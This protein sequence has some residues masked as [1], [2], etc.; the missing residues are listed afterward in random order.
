MQRKEEDHLNYIKEINAFRQWKSQNR[1]S[2]NT[3]ALWYELMALC[4]ALNWRRNSPCRQ[5]S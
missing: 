3:Q 5:S 4:N 1:I 2:G